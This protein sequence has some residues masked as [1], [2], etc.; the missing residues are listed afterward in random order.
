MHLHVIFTFPDICLR[1]LELG[2]IVPV[3]KAVPI[4]GPKSVSWDGDTNDF[5]AGIRAAD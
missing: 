2:T 3:K 4:G 5:V 1:T